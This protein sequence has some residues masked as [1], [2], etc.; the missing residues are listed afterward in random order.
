M[1]AL[2]YPVEIGYYT[3]RPYTQM[4]K[5]ALYKATHTAKQIMQYAK[6][7]TGFKYHI[8]TPI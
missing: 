7:N 5:H 6:I 8:Q 2:E 4:A 1:L 3:L